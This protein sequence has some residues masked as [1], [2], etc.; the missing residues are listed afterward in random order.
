MGDLAFGKPFTNMVTGQENPAV[1]A[2]H[3]HVGMMGTLLAIPWFPLLVS[4]TG[5]NIGY[6]EF[7]AVCGQILKEK[8]QV[9]WVF[10][11]L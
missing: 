4:A 2:M 8:L 6:G 10:N 7:Y 5:L 3:K 1:H 11:T 9:S